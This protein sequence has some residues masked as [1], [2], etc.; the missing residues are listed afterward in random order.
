M[1]DFEI[2]R[3]TRQCCV[4]GRELT[5]GEPFYSVL[6]P[7]GSSV[8]RRDYCAEAWPGPPENAVGWWK[9]NVP[10]QHAKKMHLAPSEVMLHYFEQIVDDPMLADERYVLALLMIR[11]RV[12]KQERIETD[13][14]G[15]ETLVMFCSKNE[16]EYRTLVAMPTAER[17]HEIQEKLGN[18]LY[19]K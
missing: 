10:E 8:V 17:A 12:V 2:Q 5:A 13:S 11:R 3:F 7:E 19:S 18:L 4:T 9:A 15:Q 16:Q 6:V 1:L 14:A